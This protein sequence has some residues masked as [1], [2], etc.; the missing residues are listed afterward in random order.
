MIIIKKLKITAENYLNNLLKEPAFINYDVLLFLEINSKEFEKIFMKIREKYIISE[1]TKINMVNL[2]TSK[3]K[4][5]ISFSNKR[6]IVQILVGS[7]H[8]K[9][10]LFELDSNYN[11][12]YFLTIRLVCDNSYKIIQKKM[13]DTIFLIFEYSKL[14][15][16]EL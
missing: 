6:I 9:D 7:Y 8:D 15:K 2:I 4:R 1:D 13:Y 16:K 14:Y 10:I 11:K 5:S 12:I 3:I